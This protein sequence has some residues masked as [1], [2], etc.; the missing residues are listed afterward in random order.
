MSPSGSAS[1]NREAFGEDGLVTY[2]VQFVWC[3]KVSDV[4]RQGES[5]PLISDE[6]SL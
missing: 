6:G 1:L 5:R 4:C 3:G 2:L